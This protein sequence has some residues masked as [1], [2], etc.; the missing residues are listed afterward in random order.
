MADFEGIPGRTELAKTIGFSISD[1]RPGS[2][3]VECTIEDKHLNMGGVAHG[4]IHATLL[5]TAM[6]GTLVS[7]LSEEEWCATAQLDVSYLNS[8]GTGVRLIAS[9]EVVRRGRN[10]AHVEGRLD[11][12]EGVKVATAK[13][14]WAIWD[15]RPKSQN[16][17]Q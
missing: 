12:E 6:G 8:V 2:C 1:F 10:I 16:G 14:T 4:G 7:L 9:A 17:S 5:D 3:V 11:S 15:S 13:G